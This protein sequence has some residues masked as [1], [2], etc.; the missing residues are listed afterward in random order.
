MTE[1]TPLNNSKTT[2]KMTRQEMVCLVWAGVSLAMGLACV[3]MNLRQAWQERKRASA[4]PVAR[5]M[6]EFMRSR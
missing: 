5:P 3:G 6:I 1:C 2:P 4:Q